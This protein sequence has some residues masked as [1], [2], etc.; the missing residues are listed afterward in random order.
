M[1]AHPASKRLPQARVTGRPWPPR[2]PS[3]IHCSKET[4]SSV[5]GD[6]GGLRFIGVR[7]YFGLRGQGHRPHGHITPG[8]AVGLGQASL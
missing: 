1:A 7:T 4:E 3:S 8:H 6:P 2:A 5:L